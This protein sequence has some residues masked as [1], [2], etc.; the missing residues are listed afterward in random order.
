MILS[1]DCFGIKKITML[2]HRWV[3]LG[4][5]TLFAC[6]KGRGF[7]LEDTWMVGYL[8]I[9]KLFVLPVIAFCWSHKVGDWKH[10]CVLHINIKTHQRT[11]QLVALLCPDPP[12]T[13]IHG[14]AAAS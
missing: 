2:F 3:T 12:G 6:S 1:H 10:E 5:E 7:K 8:R 11:T 9:K 14:L 13:A 4:N